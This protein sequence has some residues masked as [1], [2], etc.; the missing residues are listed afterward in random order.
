MPITWT[1]ESPAVITFDATDGAVAW[2]LILTN[3]GA[4]GF[5]FQ[6][7]K[8]GD[9]TTSVPSLQ[10]LKDLFAQVSVQL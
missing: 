10:F 3:A 7:Q 8:N 1:Q 9:P 4:N 6:L 5:S 2:K